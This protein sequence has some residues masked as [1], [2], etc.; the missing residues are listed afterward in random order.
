[1][2]AGLDLTYE[3]LKLGG[4]KKLKKFLKSL[5]LTYEELKL[6]TRRVL[7]QPLPV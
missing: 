4:R 3:E 5:D 6:L 2:L 7:H 1:M